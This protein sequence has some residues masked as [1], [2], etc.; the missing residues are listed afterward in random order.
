[1]GERP[2]HLM[3]E[4]NSPR[5]WEWLANLGEF[6]PLRRG[7]F[8]KKALV[9]QSITVNVLTSS[10]AVKPRNARILHFFHTAVRLHLAH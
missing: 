9:A 2:A 8:S 3:G 6:F 4:K 7:A 5:I 1:M 10:H